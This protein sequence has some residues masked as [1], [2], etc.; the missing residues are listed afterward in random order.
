MVGLIKSD[1]LRQSGP[2][3]SGSHGDRCATRMRLASVPAAWSLPIDGV[4]YSM[5]ALDQSSTTDF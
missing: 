2:V 5:A 3:M 1:A 4:L